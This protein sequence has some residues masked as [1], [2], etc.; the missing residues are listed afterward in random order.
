[1]KP[2][3]HLLRIV[4][5]LR[6]PLALG[7]GQSASEFDAPCALDANGLPYIPATS[8]AGALRAWVESSPSNDPWSGIPWF[9]Y[10]GSSDW[11][12]S[13]A[14]KGLTS[15]LRLSHAHIHNSR[16]EV[17]DGLVLP[18]SWQKDA[19]LGPLASSL[20]HREHVR[21]NHR[22]TA[23]DKG[24]FDRSFVPRGHRFTFQMEIV[25]RADEEQLWPQLKDC[26]LAALGDGSICLGGA[27]RAGFGRV[28]AVEAWSQCIDLR[29]SV[30]REQLRLWRKLDSRL[31]D[32]ARLPVKSSSES[33][34]SAPRRDVHIAIPLLAC[35]YW[36]V[37]S[38]ANGLQAPG[39]TENAADDTPY[40][41]QYVRWIS[42]SGKLDHTWMV[43]GS[44]I[45]G[46]IAHRTA[47]HLNRLEQR[48]AGQEGE[49]A[50]L[51]AVWA[52]FGQEADD[53][54]PA[55]AGRGAGAV[56]I[57]DAVPGGSPQLVRKN[58]VR[59]DRFTAGAYG[60]ALFSQDVLYGGKL[61]VS[62]RLRSAAL[63]HL[64]PDPQKRNC[65]MQAFRSALLDL[66]ESRLALGAGSAQG[67]GYFRAEK[68]EVLHQQLTVLGVEP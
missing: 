40:R 4:L 59:L 52:L 65:V 25:P 68:P 28:Q 18:S 27:Q 36:Q 17:Q 43:P 12:G 39:A 61:L 37:G 50:P 29:D 23:A 64:C 30:Q 7:S 41:E 55:E 21:I 35:D 48:W 22:G 46:A 62:L 8:L 24:K 49:T 60:G 67:L 13:D 54:Q 63:M 10:I 51:E 58:H 19:I 53:S 20:P 9:G 44:A 26:I 32:T 2:H 3:F 11:G 15:P 14:G 38:A 16:N 1:M 5:E 31:P 45:K 42:G 47:F 57:D 6:S 66:A 33:S 34:S 56:W